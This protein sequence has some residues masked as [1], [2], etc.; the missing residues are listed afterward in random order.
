MS[1]LKPCPFCGKEPTIVKLNGGYD[2]GRKDNY[3]NFAISCEK[4]GLRFQTFCVSAILKDDGELF[5]TDTK[6]KAIEAWNR[7]AET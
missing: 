3:G 1:E 5:I 4:C 6:S 7:R 2:A